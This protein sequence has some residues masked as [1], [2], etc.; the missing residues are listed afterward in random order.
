MTLPELGGVDE[1]RHVAFSTMATGLRLSS[2]A[3][4][5]GYNDTRSEASYESIREAGEALLP[6]KLDWARAKTFTGWRPS[7]PSSTPLIGSTRV[8]GLF[9]NS[10][11][12]HL[13]WTQAT[14]SARMLA[15]LITGVRPEID[16][17][18]YVVH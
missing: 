13:G 18:P 5:M 11:H 17:T 16:P 9:V 3:E 7:T 1:T 2:M 14:G 15:D 6:G 12:S 8:D 4:F 10:G